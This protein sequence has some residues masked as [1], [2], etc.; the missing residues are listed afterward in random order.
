MP[1]F[2]TVKEM[3]EKLRVPVS[4]IYARTRL[5]GQDTIPHLKVGKYLRFKEA[6]VLE[7]LERQQN[8]NGKKS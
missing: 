2:L 3:A 8:P 4:W 1:E 5:R 6:K 7:W